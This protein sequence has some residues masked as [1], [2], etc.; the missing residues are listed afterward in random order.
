MFVQLAAPALAG[1]LAVTFGWVPSEETADSPSA[2]VDG[3]DYLVKLSPEDLAALES[4][5]SWSITSELPE[6]IGPISRVRVYAGR[7][8]APRRLTAADT[9]SPR[10]IAAA[11]A[12]KRHV[13][14]KPASPPWDD[15]ATIT[16]DASD[17]VATTA[18]RRTAYQNPPYFNDLPS[19]FRDAANNTRQ[20]VEE[21]VDDFERGVERGLRGVGQTLDRLNPFGNRPSYSG[22]NTGQATPQS[23][24]GTNAYPGAGLPP[25]RTNADRNDT[26]SQTVD[27]PQPVGRP[28]SPRVAQGQAP[29]PPLREP[30]NGG[31]TG[32]R[33]N[34]EDPLYRSFGS[35]TS[36][37]Y[38]SQPDRPIT[39][40][41]RANNTGATQNET[42]R[43]DNTDP[44][45]A[46]DGWDDRLTEAE[47]DEL[48]QLRWEK[49][50]ARRRRLAELD[51]QD[52]FPPLDTSPARE[53]AYNGESESPSRTPTATSSADVD[54]WLKDRA[55][56]SLA[57][58]DDFANNKTPTEATTA[59]R[60]NDLQT[61]L[62]V[63]SVIAAC[64]VWATHMEL[65]AKYRALLRSG[66]TNYS[67][68]AA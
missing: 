55:G 34:T 60:S 59:G 35:G 27:P 4:G 50:Q 41:P 22:A 1:L 20:A 8:E 25:Y 43:V 58:E 23:T 14:A 2:S 7:G 56:D 13:V 24:P 21:G 19:D 61:F 48:E 62:M 32:D 18:E 30:S 68:S 37:Y 17:E 38:G 40:I 49:D 54:S 28:Y 45:S 53:V 36:D 9:R 44:G 51:Q 29:G 16:D 67:S 57:T 33:S 26:A 52:E 65:R 42:R 46:S 12:A 47:R 39:A 64:W 3:Y 5:K 10:Q 11:S 66:P 15:A 63:A 6:D 31:G